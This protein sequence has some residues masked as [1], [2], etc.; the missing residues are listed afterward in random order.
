VDAELKIMREQMMPS[1]EPEESYLS[2]ALGPE[3]KA[4]FFRATAA[5]YQAKPWTSVPCDLCLFSVTSEALGLHNAALS[6]VG[7][8]GEFLGWALFSGVDDFDVYLEATEAMD[9][10]EE[11]LIPAHLV[12]SFEAATEVSPALL[13][14]IATHGWTVA[15]PDAHPRLLAVNGNMEG[16]PPT[17]QEVTIAEAISLAL[18]ELAREKEVLLAAWNG[19]AFLERALKVAT[20]SGELKVVLRVPHPGAHDVP[21]DH[22]N[23]APVEETEAGARQVVESR[24]SRERPHVFDVEE[25]LLKL[26]GEPPRWIW[27]FTCSTPVC[28]CR[29]ALVLS[30][31]GEREELLLR[32]RPV[33]DAWEDHGGYGKVAEELTGVTAFSID[34]DTQEVFPPTGDIPLEVDAHP[35]LKEL[36]DRMDEDVLDA[37][38]RVWHRG[39]GE[40]LPPE[41]GADGANIEVEGWRTGDLVVWH[42]VQSTLRSDLYVL[43]ENV[44]EAVEFFGVE[45]EP[46]CADVVVDFTTIVPEDAPS[47]GYVEVDGDQVT[48]GLELEPPSKRLE[49]LW[50]AYCRRHPGYRAR[51]V[52]RH[53]IVRGLAG[54]LVPAPPK[55]SVGRNE[56]CPCGSGKKF[57]KCCGA[58]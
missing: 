17:A 57:K 31:S 50:A 44:Y 46:D 29:T 51:A 16:R 52:R 56:P 27:A 37:L 26:P 22:F 47:P 4:A 25:G 35:E 53:A 38:A 13:R 10:G 49:E 34:L 58:A 30:V 42:D 40:E 24:L 20:H 36:V 19:G 3:V 45:S 21:S 1:D 33:A 18:T 2:A 54:Q 12:L 14:E 55:V 39:K 6:V 11:S 43:G 32:G 9:R 7:Q 41:L 8:L 5:Y 28:A 23:E 15:C 48:L